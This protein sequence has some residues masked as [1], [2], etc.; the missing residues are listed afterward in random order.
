MNIYIYIRIVFDALI[1]NS[2][3]DAEPLEVP[4]PPAVPAPVHLQ[5]IAETDQLV[6]HDLSKAKITLDMDL[7]TAENNFYE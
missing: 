6:Y 4:I 2:Q 5:K 3:A 7:A 1:V